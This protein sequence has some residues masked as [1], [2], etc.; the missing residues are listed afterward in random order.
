[1]VAVVVML[2]NDGPGRCQERVD[3]C[4]KLATHRTVALSGACPSATEPSLGYSCLSK[5]WG[6]STPWMYQVTGCLVPS[7][8]TMKRVTDADKIRKSRDRSWAYARAWCSLRN[9]IS[10]APT[11]SGFVTWTEKITSGWSSGGPG[12]HESQAGSER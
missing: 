3:C 5:R 9:T 7:S 2:I 4:L 11:L 1:M 10:I 6:C 8:P 12:T